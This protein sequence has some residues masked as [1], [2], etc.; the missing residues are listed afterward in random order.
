LLLL[1]KQQQQKIVILFKISV[2]LAWAVSMLQSII[3]A[4]APID[5]F[6]N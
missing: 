5:Y 4:W 2:C 1:A 6:D 3:A